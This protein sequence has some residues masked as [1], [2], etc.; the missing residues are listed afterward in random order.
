MGFTLTETVEVK[1]L[2]RQTRMNN[3][4]RLG[5]S[6]TVSTSVNSLLK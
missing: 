1:G 3:I 5:E 6:G 4:P 2:E